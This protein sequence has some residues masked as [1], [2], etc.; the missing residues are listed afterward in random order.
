MR[1]GL[2]G[3]FSMLADLKR[4][5]LLVPGNAESAE[6]LEEAAPSGMSLLHGNGATVDGVRFFGLGYAVPMTPFGDWSCDLSEETATEMLDR[7]EA[8]DVLITHSPPRGVGDR[9]SAGAHVGST[10][11]KAASLACSRNLR[12]LAKS[13]IAGAS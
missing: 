8:A 1:S 5:C 4:P 2:E 11:I 3:A 6:E 13:T 10:A 9:T 7:C 12:S